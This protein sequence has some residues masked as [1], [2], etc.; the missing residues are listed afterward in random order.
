[1]PLIRTVLCRRDAVEAELRDELS[2]LQQQ[3]LEARAMRDS[4]RYLSLVQR[5]R[6]N[7]IILCT[8]ANNRYQYT[9]MHE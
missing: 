5:R 3:I 4:E 1:M 6:P 9:G 8:M 2:Q 7:G